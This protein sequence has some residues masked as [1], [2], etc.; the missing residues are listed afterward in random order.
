[1]DDMER[2]GW[3]IHSRVHLM[4]IGMDEIV[5]DFIN[6]GECILVKLTNVK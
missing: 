5:L 6:R 2:L 1:M 3:R 4:S